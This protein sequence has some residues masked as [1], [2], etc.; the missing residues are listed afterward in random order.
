MNNENSYHLTIQVM[1]MK[2]TSQ[3]ATIRL[4]RGRNY[5]TTPSGGVQILYVY[6]HLE[7]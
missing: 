2:E 5:C 3:R 1:G 7:M 6:I 4:S